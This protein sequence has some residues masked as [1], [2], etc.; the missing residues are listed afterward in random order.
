MARAITRREPAPLAWCGKPSWIQ[1]RRI[2]APKRR[3]S[4]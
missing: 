2:K 4:K 3:K 1:T